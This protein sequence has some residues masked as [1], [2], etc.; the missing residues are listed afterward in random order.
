MLFEELQPKPAERQIAEIVKDD[1]LRAIRTNS[2]SIKELFKQPPRLRFIIGRLIN[3]IDPGKKKETPMRVIPEIEAH[4][5]KLKI[6]ERSP[7]CP[8]VC[9]QCGNIVP[10]GDKVNECRV[11]GSKKY[12]KV[13]YWKDPFFQEVD[14]LD[15]SEAGNSILKEVYH[16][17]VPNKKG[18]AEF[19]L[20]EAFGIM[21]KSGKDCRPCSRTTAQERVWWY[22]EVPPVPTETPE[23]LSPLEALKRKH[24]EKV[25]VDALTSIIEGTEAKRKGISHASEY[26]SRGRDKRDTQEPVSGG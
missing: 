19:T 22:D 14:R 3:A 2:L 23:E 25:L 21:A 6:I 20:K 1:L 10:Y 26:E 7:N 15:G 9:V 24:G 18:E 5:V 13:F 17:K 4:R 8:R 12:Q 11:C 16:I